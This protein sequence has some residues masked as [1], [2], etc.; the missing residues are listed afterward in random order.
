MIIKKDATRFFIPSSM[1]SA[2]NPSLERYGADLAVSPEDDI[3]ATTE[4]ML[5]KHI[6]HG[7]ILMKVMTVTEFIETPREKL[8][9]LMVLMH[10]YVVKT[11]AQR[12]LVIVGEFGADADKLVVNGQ[13]LKYTYA[14]FIARL[15]SWSDIGGIGVLIPKEAFLM[16]YI[17][18]REM[19]LKYYKKNTGEIWTVPDHNLALLDTMQDWQTTLAT[20]PGIGATKAPAI[21]A[22]VESKKLIDA[23]TQL[24]DWNVRKKL[25]PSALEVNTKIR[26]WFGLQDGWNIDLTYVGE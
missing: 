23:I 7:A 10:D 21:Y 19:T 17:S 22:G 6:E 14:E 2:V 26:A 13:T 24:T 3:P 25:G 20:L 8:K 1:N 12:C 16:P 5:E 4:R 15:T 18:I 9:E 11:N